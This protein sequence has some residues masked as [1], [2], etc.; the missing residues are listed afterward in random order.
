MSSYNY[1]RT[2]ATPPTMIIV[3]ELA[4]GD[5]YFSKEQPKLS[6]ATKDA[7]VKYRDLMENESGS[8][9]DRAKAAS[10]LDQALVNEGSLLE[11]WGSALKTHAR[12]YQAAA[13]SHRF[14]SRG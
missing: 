10:A 13:G 2:A 3:R 12:A 7:A 9:A 6:K 8:E 4:K 5:S 11:A 14:K 1:D